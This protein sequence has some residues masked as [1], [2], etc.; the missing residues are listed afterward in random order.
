MFRI[1]KPHNK[2]EPEMYGRTAPGRASEKSLSRDALDRERHRAERIDRMDEDRIGAAGIE[3]THS[4]QS[5]GSGDRSHKSSRT[6]PPYRSPPARTAPSEHKAMD[7]AWGPTGHYVNYDEIQQN[8][9]A[10]REKLSEVQIGQMRRQVRAQRE[11]AVEESRRAG[12]GSGGYHSQRS[13]KEGGARPQS[14]YYEYETAPPR[15]PGKL[16]HYH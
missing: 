1:G 5:S 2:P 12:V 8:L 9:N 14:N 3:V 6:A 11:K 15:R 13:C 7:S 16:S 10:R 4:R